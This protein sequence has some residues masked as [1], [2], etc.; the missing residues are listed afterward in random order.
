MHR[1]SGLEFFGEKGCWSYW[2]K[3]SRGISLQNQGISDTKFWYQVVNSIHWGSS[4]AFLFFSLGLIPRE[5][6]ISWE[7]IDF[8]PSPWIQDSDGSEIM[9]KY[10]QSQCNKLL[11]L[12]FVFHQ[13]KCEQHFHV[14][15]HLCVSW[16]CHSQASWLWKKTSCLRLGP[17][18]T[19]EQD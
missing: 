8:F 16:P 17:N 7:T 12:H 9:S 19:E 14:T 4:A 15:F 5:M 10:I 1:S 13:W 6:E 2:T 3:N 18:R 11:L